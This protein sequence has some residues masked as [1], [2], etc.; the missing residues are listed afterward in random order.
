MPAAATWI[1]S[2]DALAA[3]AAR[4]QASTA[5]VALDTEFVF[6]RTTARG[7]ASSRSPSTA[8]SR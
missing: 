1:D 2:P 4:W 5:D 7:S 3:T 6:E 8:R